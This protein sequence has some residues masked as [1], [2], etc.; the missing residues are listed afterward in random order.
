MIESSGIFFALM[1]MIF[2]G[3]EELFLKEAI[4]R[5]KS[6]TT[7]LINTAVGG[8]LSL[9]IV[10]FFLDSKISFIPLEDL[11]VSFGVAL[12]AF[13]GYLMFYFA[14]E[15]QELSLIAAL[16]ESWI[17]VAVFA[18][19]AVFGETLGLTHIFSIV[20]ILVGAFLISADFSKLKGLK[21]ISGSGY[22]ALAVLFIG[23]SVPLEKTLLHK[24]GEANTILYLYI[25]YFLLIFISRPLLK[26]KFVKPDTKSFNLSSLSGLADGAAWIFY[27]LALGSTDV[28]VV[29]PIVASSVLVSVVLAHIFLK[30]KMTP[31]QMLGAGLILISVIALSILVK[32]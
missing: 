23:L 7:L 19:V 5:V 1:A 25:F 15:R 8:V 21:F 10:A 3:I 6:H 12:V 24:I 20:A 31:K 14:L 22:E 17:I 9:G 16:D 18:G 29:S 4:D 13:I 2:W 26:Q 27:L 11:F 28:S 32:V 30:E